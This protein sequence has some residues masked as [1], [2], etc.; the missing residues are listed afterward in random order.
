MT[1]AQKHWLD[2]ASDAAFDGTHIFPPM[3]ACE[4][5]LESGYGNSSLYLTHFNGFGMKQHSHPVY[6][7]VSLPT[8]EFLGG[9][10]Q[11]VNAEFISYPDLKACFSDRMNT[12]RR[13]STVYPHYAAALA[14]SD[15]IKYVTEVSKSWSTD[16][17]RAL[18]CIAI[19]NG[20]LGGLADSPN[21]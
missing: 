2:A 3:A 11:K 5:A 7:T 12:L 6:N 18:K 8:S 16:P 14:A 1:D 20:W 10:W 13:L 21:E 17:D 9:E 19:Y 4:M 15:P